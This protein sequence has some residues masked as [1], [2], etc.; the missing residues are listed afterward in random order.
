M[1]NRASSLLIRNN[2]IIEKNFDFECMKKIYICSPL[3]GNAKQN[4]KEAKKYCRYVVNKGSIP[5]APHIYFTQFLDDGIKKERNL[6]IKMLKEA[7]DGASN[8]VAESIETEL[9]N[10]ELE[11]EKKSNDSKIKSIKSDDTT[12]V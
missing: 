6:G 7:Y 11:E 2:F 8:E 4:I 10:L 9:I 1:M 5:I 12:I 3:R